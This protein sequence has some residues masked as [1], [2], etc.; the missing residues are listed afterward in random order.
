MMTFLSKTGLQVRKNSLNTS[1]PKRLEETKKKSNKILLTR[2]KTTIVGLE[3]VIHHGTIDMTLNE[4]KNIFKLRYEHRNEPPLDSIIF[5]L[6]IN[7]NC[8]QINCN[9]VD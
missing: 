9:I 6:G 1:S 4:L 8:P 7:E 5:K 2:M 3:K